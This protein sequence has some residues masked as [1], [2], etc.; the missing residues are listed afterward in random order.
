MEIVPSCSC[1]YRATSVKRLGLPDPRIGFALSI[2]SRLERPQTL[3][4]LRVLVSVWNYHKELV[5]IVI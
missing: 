3:Y 4:V 1:Y 2:V 5:Y